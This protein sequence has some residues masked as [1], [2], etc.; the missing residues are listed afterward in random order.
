[1]SHERAES[2]LQSPHSGLERSLIDEYLQMRGHTQASLHALPEA[3]RQTLLAEASLYA[4]SRLSE[5]DARSH[6]VHDMHG[7]PDKPPPGME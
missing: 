6:Y 3:Q 4:S 7:R 1:M 2:P 5:V